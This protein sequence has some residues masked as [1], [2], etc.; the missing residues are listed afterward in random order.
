MAFFKWKGINSIVNGSKDTLPVS[1]KVGKMVETKDEQGKTSDNYKEKQKAFDDFTSKTFKTSECEWGKAVDINLAGRSPWMEIAIAEAKVYGGKDEGTID[2][3]I[4]TYH[5]DGGGTDAGSGT[6]WCASFV[7]WCIEQKDLPSPHSAG[8]RMF[9]T[10]AKAEKCEAFFG[11]VA[12][13]SDCN[14]TGTNIETS[15]HA[16]FVFGKLPGTEIYACLGGN[17]S[18]KL[19]MSSYNCSGNV[20]VSWKEKNGTEHY[21]IFRGF[22]KPKGY[23]IK[24]LD[25]LNNNDN[26]SSADEASKKALNLDI[27]SDENGESSR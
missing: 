21:K 3:R 23:V 24:D 10:S 25:K 15:G 5:K 19:K 11:A 17:Q 1:K 26:Y 14:S 27:K 4:K 20:F 12:I 6:A 8:S 9:L 7:C 2:S 16:T 13:F 18:D 22:Y